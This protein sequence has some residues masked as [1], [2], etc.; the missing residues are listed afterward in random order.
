MPTNGPNAS[1]NDVGTL[2]EKY[3]RT[4]IVGN[5]EGGTLVEAAT[6]VKNNILT[7]SDSATLASSTVLDQGG[8]F[9]TSDAF[10]MSEAG[11][12]FG[13]VGADN[14]TLS[15]DLPVT[16][17]VDDG[18]EGVLA[19]SDE[20]IT[21][22]VVAGDTG[23]LADTAVLTTFRALS[24]PDT[25]TLAEATVLVV[26]NP[27]VGDTATLAEGVELETGGALQVSVS[28][29]DTAALVE[30]ASVTGVGAPFVDA[31]VAALAEAATITVAFVV[32]DS[33]TVAD[34]ATVAMTVTLVDTLTLV[35]RA[36]R[37]AEVF[38]GTAKF[39]QVS[40]GVRV[41][42]TV[43]IGRRGGV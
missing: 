30:T 16:I 6:L 34:A 26:T 27:T 8:I 32:G 40:L 36:T 21:A 28:A 7:A 3:A 20:T 10:T 43:T 33:G 25:A 14:Y 17:G 5:Q 22:V 12:V 42:G 31:D 41:A 1:D 35:E 11:S 23:T 38:A 29:S 19:E 9:F 24:G 39:A 18:P 15:D 13:P 2:A 4:T 37:L